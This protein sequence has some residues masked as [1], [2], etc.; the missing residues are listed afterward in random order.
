MTL[1]TTPFAEG[2]DYSLTSLTTDGFNTAETNSGIF[3]VSSN[4]SVCGLNLLATNQTTAL[5]EFVI[6]NTLNNTQDDINW[7]LDTGDAN[8]TSTFNFNLTAYEDIFVYIPSLTVSFFSLFSHIYL[9]VDVLQKRLN[10]GEFMYF[11]AVLYF[12]AFFNA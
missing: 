8:I 10:Y 4:L 9:T 12:L 6:T 1:N 2:D 3:C 5:F 11:R 7:T